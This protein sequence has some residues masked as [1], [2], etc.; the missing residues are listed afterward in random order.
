M[1][2]SKTSSSSPQFQVHSIIVV[3]KQRVPVGALLGGWST[4]ARSAFT[5]V[6]KTNGWRTVL[7][8]I[9]RAVLSMVDGRGI[10]LDQIV[11][12]FHVL[13]RRRV[14]SVQLRTHVCTN[15]IVSLLQS[16]FQFCSKRG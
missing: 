2:N 15:T 12:A 10:T 16:N 14:L 7:Q 4:V 6:L 5:D 11:L 9:N 3:L 1:K 13:S 8:S